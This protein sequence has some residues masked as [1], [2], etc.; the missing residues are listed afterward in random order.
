MRNLALVAALVFLCTPAMAAAHITYSTSDA[1][2]ESLFTGTMGLNNEFGGSAEFNYAAIIDPA[3]TAPYLNTRTL[4]GDLT[5]S[6]D[7]LYNITGTVT[8]GDNGEGFV[9]NFISGDFQSSSVT[10]STLGLDL[11]GR[12]V[13]T[14]TLLGDAAGS[15][16]LKDTFVGND[17][18][19]IPDWESFHQAN[20]TLSFDTSA[21][22]LAEFF[23]D[24]YSM[25]EGGASLTLQATSVP[26]PMTMTLLLAG[27][28]LLASR[29]RTAK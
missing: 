5:V 6:D 17:T 26:E 3:T 13:I 28:G 22:S 4:S 10:Y 8:I 21:G 14:G 1:N 25:S 29:R 12:I 11:G 19:D 20:M 2:L 18:I 23:T 24:D 27:V 15:L 7:G 16:V 9:S